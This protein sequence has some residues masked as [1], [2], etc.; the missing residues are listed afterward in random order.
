V[1]KDIKQF[2]NIKN[3][4]DLT[5]DMLVEFSCRN[6]INIGHPKFE[7]TTNSE[8]CSSIAVEVIKVY[9]LVHAGSLREV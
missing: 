1:V 9:Y 8:T 7:L 2:L 6:L 5:I 3:P 4:G